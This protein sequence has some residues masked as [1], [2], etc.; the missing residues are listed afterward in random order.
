MLHRH[1]RTVV[2]ALV[3]AAMML[4]AP[5]FAQ[6]DA[7]PAKPAAAKKKKKKATIDYEGAYYKPGTGLTI[8]S[9][10]GRF[11]NALRLRAQFRY[12]G[13]GPDGAPYDHVFMIRRARIQW[14]G[15]SFGKTNKFKVEFAFSPRDLSFKPGE[16]VGQIPILSWYLDLGK[17]KN[18]K[19]KMGQYKVPFNKQRVI[20]SGNL[21]LVDRAIGNGEFNVDRDTGIEIHSKDLFGMGMFQ[22][23]LGVFMNRGRNMTDKAHRIEPHMMYLARFEVMPFGKFKNF[24]EGDLKR[25]AKPRLAV[26]AA[27]GYLDDAIKDRGIL[28]KAPKDGGTTDITTATADVLFKMSGFSF[29]SELYWRKGDRTVGDALDDKGVAIAESAARDGMGYFAQAGYV[30]GDAPYEVAARFGQV[31]GADD[32][33]ALSDKNEVGAAVSWYPGG[34]AW[35]I[36]AD[37]YNEWGDSGFDKGNKRFRIQMQAA[38]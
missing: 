4:A 9:K 23:N 16:G 36:Q 25:L 18:F 6:T 3:T 26:G 27:F 19:V 1:T 13:H 20:S 2:V 37:W 32:K 17:N 29:F 7:A 8:N 34:H 38:Y 30:F 22:Y 31:M 12:E 14:K 33:S 15:H 24:S 5:A 35:K 10:D 21:Q 28:G 11:G